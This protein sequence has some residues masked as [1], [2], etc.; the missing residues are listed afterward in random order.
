MVFPFRV[1]VFS[2]FRDGDFFISFFDLANVHAALYL[3]GMVSPSV[4]L[5]MV[6]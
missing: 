6:S 5:A 1:S 4:S 3:W 2:C